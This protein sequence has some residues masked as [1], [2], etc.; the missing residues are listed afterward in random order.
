MI[1]F[2]LLM[3]TIAAELTNSSTFCPFCQFLNISLPQLKSWKTQSFNPTPIKLKLPERLKAN[4][5]LCDKIAI[6]N[7]IWHLVINVYCAS[8]FLFNCFI[9]WID[10]SSLHTF[11][12]PF[13]HPVLIIYFYNKFL[14]AV[15]IDRFFSFA[16]LVYICKVLIYTLFHGSINIFECKLLAMLYLYE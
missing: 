8:F 3:Y 6:L 16:F 1:A 11:W 10:W 9:L 4:N 2:Y 13:S 15:L 12:V 7:Y 14:F 5:L